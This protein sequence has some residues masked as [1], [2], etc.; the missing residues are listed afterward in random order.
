MVDKWI[1]RCLV[2]TGLIAGL[3]TAVAQDEVSADPLAGYWKQKNDLSFNILIVN[4]DGVYDAEIIRSDWSPGLIG[5][6]L[7][8]DVVST[9]KNRWA[10]EADIIGS[11][12]IAKVSLR[13]KRSGELTTKVRPGDSIIWL[14]SEPVEKR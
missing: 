6:K 13:I 4:S 1:R 5:T 12:R 9:K 14:R 3:G 11:S 2:V 8:R 10:G 7:F